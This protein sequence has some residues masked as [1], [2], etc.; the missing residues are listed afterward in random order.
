MPEDRLPGLRP[1]GRGRP[2]VIAAAVP[3]LA[4]VAIVVGIA[5]GTNTPAS[6]PA[7][8]VASASPTPTASP[9]PAPTV[10]PGPSAV[11][12]FDRAARSTGDPTSLWVVVNK[13]RPLTP[14]DYLPADLVDVPV[15]YVFE[16]RLRREASVAALAMFA[17]IT[18][19][20]GLRLQSQSA[21]RGF[22]AQTRVY[23]QGVGARGEASTDA[24]IARPGYSEHQTG[25]AVDIASLPA[26]CALNA[27]FAETPHGQWLRQN[28]WR[29]G[30]LLRYPA[31]RVAVTGYEFEPWHFRYVGRDLAAEMH[32]TG[33]TT[34][35]E[36]FHL[37]A[38]P[39]YD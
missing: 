29:F 16:P 31:D 23:N 33:S 12:T 11:A 6:G 14:L 26:E 27:C 21:Y 5:V 9:R 28:A 25:L 38:A 36:F 7:A 18:E 34:L 35:E 37:P 30:Y 4:T 24:S 20:T 2:S 3:L 22:E 17:A 8:P 32:R 19:E 15:P 1:A 13:Q 10:T 39:G